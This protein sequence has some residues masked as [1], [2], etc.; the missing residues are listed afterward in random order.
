M[1]R[2][3]RVDCEKKNQSLEIR[4]AYPGYLGR[5]ENPRNAYSVLRAG[6]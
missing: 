6:K 4:N 5:L 2:H 3:L 1:E